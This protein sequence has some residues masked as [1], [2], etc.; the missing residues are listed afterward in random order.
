MNAD[1]DALLAQ[2]AANLAKRYPGHEPATVEAHVRQAYQELSAGADTGTD[3]YLPVLIE[4]AVRDRLAP[5]A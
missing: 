5:P 1:R 2:I 3:A 4:N